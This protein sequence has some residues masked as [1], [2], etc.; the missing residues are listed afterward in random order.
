MHS[1]ATK[2]WQMSVL[3]TEEKSTQAM[4][5][6]LWMWLVT[7]CTKLFPDCR[8]IAYN[9]IKTILLVE[10]CCDILRLLDLQQQGHLAFKKTRFTKT[11]LWETWPKL[12]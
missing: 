2:K 12:N 3:L 8:S 6:I 5:A 11:C 9:T 10:C 4:T 1:I 7:R